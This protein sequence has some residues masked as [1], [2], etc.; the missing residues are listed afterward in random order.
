MALRS[1]RICGPMMFRFR[2]ISAPKRRAQ[3]LAGASDER[4][5]FCDE[6]ALATPDSNTGIVAIRRAEHLE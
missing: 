4:N 5:L 6:Q 2:F 3:R 1:R